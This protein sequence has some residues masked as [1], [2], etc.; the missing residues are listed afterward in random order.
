MLASYSTF[1]VMAP[2]LFGFGVSLALDL[3]RGLLTL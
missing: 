1:G 2:G 3:V